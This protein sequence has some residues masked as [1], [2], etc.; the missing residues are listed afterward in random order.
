SRLRATISQEWRGGKGPFDYVRWRVFH[1][2][3][4]TSQD[5]IED[6]ETLVFGA[7]GAV[8]RNRG[9]VFDQKLQGA[10]LNLASSFDWLGVTHALSYGFEYERAETEQIRIGTE[11]DLISGQTSN[12]VGPDTFPVRDFPVS[13]TSRTGVYL[14]NAIRIGDVTLLPGVRYDRFTLDPRPDAIFLADNPGIESVAIDDAQVS[15]KFG[16]TWQMT[17]SVQIYGQYSEGFR[18]PPV[19]DVNIGFT[20]LQFGYTAL[21]NPDLRSESSRG[22]ESGIRINTQTGRYEFAAFETRYDDFI[23]SLQVVGFDPILQVIQFQS[24]NLGN[25]RIRGAEFSG[26]YQPAALPDGFQIRLAAAYAEGENRDNNQPVN[27]IAPLNG[28]FGVDYLSPA[29]QWGL[30][31]LARGAARQDDLN[32]TQGE[33][34][35]PAGYV[36]YDMTGFWKPTEATRLR[37][38]VFNL[39]D[40]AFTPYLDVQGIPSDTV[41]AIR[42]QRPG[43]E[44]NVALDWRF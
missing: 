14:Q 30:S 5:T 35:S 9:F 1:Q 29:E 42:F 33:L 37:F 2:E 11:T 13:R 17:D 10:E 7:P 20:N 4:E 26:S 21:P 41:D 19:N 3:S 18:A 43:R 36:I 8:R 22:L 31:A 23:E 15:P 24:I 28:V 39:T 40:H 12:T 27:S 38:G 25:V 44:F 32:E 16:A 34:L 6:R